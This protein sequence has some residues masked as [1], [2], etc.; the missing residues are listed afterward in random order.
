MLRTNA[1]KKLLDIMYIDG[2]N[3]ACVSGLSIQ[4]E[5]A[6]LERTGANHKL[7]GFGVV[8]TEETAKSI[9]AGWYSLS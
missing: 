4:K 2:R 3:S 6:E 9:Q 1:S 7:F 8:S 5:R